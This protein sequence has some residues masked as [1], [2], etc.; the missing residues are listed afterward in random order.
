[1]SRRIITA[2]KRPI[3]KDCLYL[4]SSMASRTRTN[5]RMTFRLAAFVL[6]AAALLAFACSGDDD[7]APGSGSGP[8]DVIAFGAE[9]PDGDG[10]YIVK[11][12]G[13]GLRLLTAESGFVAYPMWSPG[14]GRIAY[15]AGVPGGVDPVLL[16]LYEF[17]TDTALTVSTLAVAGQFGAPATWSPDG[18]RIAFSEVAGDA[19]RLRVY[20]LERAEL[21]DSARVSGRSPSWSP[22][23]EELAFVSDSGQGGLLVMDVAGGEPEVLASRPGGEEGPRWSPDGDVIAVVEG[24]EGEEAL[25][26]VERASGAVTELG[27]GLVPSWSPDGRRL[28]FSAPSEDGKTDL[29][30]FFIAIE[31]GA[32]QPLSQSTTRDLW[33]AWSPDG[34]SVALLSQVDRQS[35][36]ICVVRLQP[37]GRDCLSLPGLLPA[38]PAWSPR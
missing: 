22:D 9:G 24:E 18:R 19:P 35:A 17:E 21:I 34:N 1:M 23:G 29:D 13:S 20:D 8:S 3:N 2:V 15:V 32:R 25:L 11:P 6:I 14:G 37:E 28:V 30:I 12:D 7:A 36:F 31:G 4:S 16:R 26:L 5:G 10:L 27:A 38:T 33:P